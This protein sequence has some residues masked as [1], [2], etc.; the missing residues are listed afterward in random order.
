MNFNKAMIDLV[1]EVR[2]R[3]P[4]ELKPAIK[5]ANPDLFSELATHYKS[6]SDAVTRALIKELFNLAG[7]HWPKRLTDE[8]TPS[9]RLVSHVYRGQVQH[10]PTT[11][12]P[13]QTVK[14]STKSSKRIYRGQVVT[15]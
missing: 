14:T 13:S 3:V 7:D 15:D 1:H 9:Q 10:V 2:R 8:D 5:L 11:A 12:H 4:S 6:G